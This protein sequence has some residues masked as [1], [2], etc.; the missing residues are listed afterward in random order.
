MGLQ[1]AED[2][3][4]VEPKGHSCPREPGCKMAWREHLGVSDPESRAMVC[5]RQASAPGGLSVL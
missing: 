3:D 1:E 5:G 4:A 2:R